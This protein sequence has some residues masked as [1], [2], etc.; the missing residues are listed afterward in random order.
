[1][2]AIMRGIMPR[3]NHILSASVECACYGV[4]QGVHAAHTHGAHLCHAF[5]FFAFLNPWFDARRGD[6]TG[7]QAGARRKHACDH[8]SKDVAC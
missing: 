1:M 3:L 6:G 8:A 2:Y 5:P 7:T 4:S